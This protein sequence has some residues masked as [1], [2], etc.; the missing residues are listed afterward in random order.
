MVT[1]KFFANLRDLVHKKE[2]QIE[3]KNLKEAIT[4]AEKLLGIDLIGELFEDGKPKKGVIVLVNGKNIEHLQGL[5]T[6]L[7]DGD[8][9]SLFPPVGGG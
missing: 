5:L 2:I 4:N 3:G 8:I 6:P 7:S 9:V 1:L